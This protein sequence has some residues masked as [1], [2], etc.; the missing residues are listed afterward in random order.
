MCVYFVYVIPLIA[1]VFM[2][3]RN[4][5]YGCICH[6]YFIILGS[7][8]K[9]CYMCFYEHWAAIPVFYALLIIPK[10]FHRFMELPTGFNASNSLH[11]CIHCQS[12]YSVLSPKFNY[13]WK[14]RGFLSGLFSRVGIYL[15]ICWPDFHY[16]NLP[17]Y[18]ASCKC[19]LK[20]D[21]QYAKCDLFFPSIRWS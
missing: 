10:A 19:C 3:I 13:Q 20:Y 18:I 14:R 2:P 21:N 6:G 17:P 5:G 11:A 12:L 9:R 4:R 8:D 16:S 1:G 7:I 15:Y